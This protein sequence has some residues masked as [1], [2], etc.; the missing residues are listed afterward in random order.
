[1]FVADAA[2][3]AA[4]KASGVLV[5][6]AQM[7]RSLQRLCDSSLPQQLKGAKQLGA[8]SFGGVHAIKRRLPDGSLACCKVRGTARSLLPGRHPAQP[9]APTPVHLLKTVLPP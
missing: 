8:G 7:Q 9:H 2:A 6:A 1:M 5:H 3:A 4:T